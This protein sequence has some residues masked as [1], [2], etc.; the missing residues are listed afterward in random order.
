M[1][2]GLKTVLG[3]D[4][5]LTGALAWLDVTGALVDVVDMPVVAGDLDTEALLALLR[6]GEPY[7]GLG[8]VTAV[9]E[10]PGLMPGNGAKSAR[11]MGMGL[12]RLETAILACSIPVTRVA[13]NAWKRAMGLSAD[14]EASRALAKRTWPAT[15]YFDRKKDDG[16]AEAALL[17]RWWLTKASSWSISDWVTYITENRKAL[18]VHGYGGE[19]M[20]R[21]K[22]ISEFR[23]KAAK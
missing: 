8:V 1:T 14:K 23:K 13:P 5:G 4:P 19:D 18:V 2:H 7:G 20:F 16:R 11:S 10:W 12:G 21:L 6:Q 22:E 15:G 3:V 9:L 17:A